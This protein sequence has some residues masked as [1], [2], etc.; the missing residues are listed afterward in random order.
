MEEFWTFLEPGKTDS[1]S[2]YSHIPDLP[3]S[4][5]VIKRLTRPG[6]EI[7]LV[8]LILNFSTAVV[9]KMERVEVLV[10]RKIV[11]VRKSFEYI[12]ANSS[13]DF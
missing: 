10:P 2:F 11:R 9:P 12:C 1:R 6:T 7:D 5:E 8:C 3:E 4:K 13:F